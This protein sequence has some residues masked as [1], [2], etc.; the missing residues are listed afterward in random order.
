MIIRNC[1]NGVHPFITAI[2]FYFHL[3]VVS[4]L[5][6]SPWIAGAPLLSLCQ[7][8]QQKKQEAALRMLLS[9]YV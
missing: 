6:L 3:P 4:R 7:S 9:V 5:F 1:F 8:H 2:H